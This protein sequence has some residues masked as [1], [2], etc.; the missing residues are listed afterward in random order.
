MID[1]RR[2]LVIGPRVGSLS[3]LTRS[4]YMA[5]VNPKLIARDLRVAVDGGLKVFNKFWRKIGWKPHFAVGDWDSL[6]SEKVSHA[7]RGIFHLTLPRNKDR[8]DLYYACRAAMSAGATDLV[9]LGVTG[10]RADHQLATLFDLSEIAHEGGRAFS[11]LAV[12]NETRYYFISENH[13]E[14]SIDVVPGQTVS[15]FALEGEARGVTLQ[16]F[17]YPLKN[18]VLQ[19]SSHG[20]SNIALK[21]QCSIKVRKGRVVVLVLSGA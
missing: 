19:P 16:G 10:G 7:L 21:T 6:G 13:P 9:C 12:D 17:K 11:V 14:L 20:L 3:E 18:A 4:L 2:A 5:G 8:S 15:V 1:R